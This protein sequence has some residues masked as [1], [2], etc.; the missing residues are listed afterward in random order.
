MSNY[1]PIPVDPAPVQAVKLDPSTGDVTINGTTFT[2]GNWLVVASDGTL[3][4]MDDAAFTAAYELA[5][6]G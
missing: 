2:A 4:A 1:V 5:P 3:S 6:A